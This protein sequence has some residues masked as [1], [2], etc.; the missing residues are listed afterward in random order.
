[1]DLSP[2][3]RE[4][5]AALEARFLRLSYRDFTFTEFVAEWDAITIEFAD[6]YEA[7]IDDDT[8]DLCTRDIL[9]DLLQA[10]PAGLREKLAS[11]LT[12][13]DERFRQAT[14]P[15]DERLI[16]LYFRHGPGWWWRRRP[17]RGPLATYLTTSDQ[18]PT[19]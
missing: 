11:H 16:G 19:P 7:S 1:M 13:A 18:P 6:D 3:E 14:V 15:D 2:G 17:A 12:A 5:V 4:I 10:A 9:D 8:N